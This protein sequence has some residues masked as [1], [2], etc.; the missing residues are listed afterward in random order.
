MCLNWFS[1][2]YGPPGGD[3]DLREPERGRKQGAVLI[4]MCRHRLDRLSQRDSQD[5]GRMI[6][7]RVFHDCSLVSGAST[8]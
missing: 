1:P 5:P 2:V 6:F 8:A 4:D 7:I 3:Q